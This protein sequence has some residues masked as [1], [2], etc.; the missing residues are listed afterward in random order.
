M[1][2]A[3]QCAIYALIGF[4]QEVLVIVYHR[5]TY[6]GQKILASITTS[7]MTAVSLLVMVHITQQILASGPLSFLLVLVFALGK[8]VGAYTT[9]SWWDRFGVVPKG[10]SQ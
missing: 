7:L 6:S 5:A 2:I 4:I 8:G 3:L 9:L 10:K 1:S